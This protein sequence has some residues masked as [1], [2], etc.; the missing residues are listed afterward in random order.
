[1]LPEV[2]RTFTESSEGPNRAKPHLVRC[3]DNETMVDIF[4]GAQNV[5]IL[6]ELNFALQICVG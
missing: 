4:A 3:S 2:V 5:C 6:I 1:M